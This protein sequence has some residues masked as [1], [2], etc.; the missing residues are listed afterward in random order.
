MKSYM[1]MEMEY[2]TRFNKTRSHTATVFY[3]GDIR[4]IMK[5]YEITVDNILSLSLDGKQQDPKELLGHD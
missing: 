4:D 2:R 5:R 1:W 3:K